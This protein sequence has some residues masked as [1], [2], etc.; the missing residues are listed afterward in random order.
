MLNQIWP[1][2]VKIVA[3][4][5]ELEIV[6]EIFN[7]LYT[8]P[9]LSQFS[10]VGLSSSKLYYGVLRMSDIEKNDKRAEERH[11]VETEIA[12]NAENDIYMANSVDIS[13]RGIRIVTESPIDIRFQIKENDKL[14]QYHAQL[15]WALK[16]D[17][18]SME[19]GLK[20]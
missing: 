11:L 16:R 5:L 1:A 6:S 20:Y 19:Y 12:F 15:V 9:P 18:G 3:R 2:K 14:V 8:S 10:G 4:N 7:P 13:A 17:D